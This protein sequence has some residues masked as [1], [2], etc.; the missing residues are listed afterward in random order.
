MDININTSDNEVETIEKFKTSGYIHMD[1]I[2]TINNLVNGRK[3]NIMKKIFWKI[4]EKIL[5]WWWG[6]N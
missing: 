5:T 3:S 2:I 1:E 6:E 4:R